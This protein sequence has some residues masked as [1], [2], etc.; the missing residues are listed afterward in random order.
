VQANNSGG[1]KITQS[2]ANAKARVSCCQQLLTANLR[3]IFPFANRGE[4]GIVGIVVQ[5]AL[6]SQ[7]R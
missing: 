4:Y 2:L 5:A 7:R 1:R 3:L 6:L